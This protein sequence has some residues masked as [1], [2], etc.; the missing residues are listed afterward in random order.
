[1]LKNFTIITT[2]GC[3][4]K[5]DFCFDP[6]NKPTGVDYLL[7][8]EDALKSMPK[9]WNQVSISGGEPTISPHF[10][11]VLKLVHKQKHVKKVVLTTNGTKLLEHIDIIAKSVNHLNV[12]RHAIGYDENVKIFKNKQIID[13]GDLQTA[14]KILSLSGVD[15]TLNCVYTDDNMMTTDFVFDFVR[16]AQFLGASVCFRYDCRTTE[17]KDITPIEQDLIDI[18]YK[19]TFKSECP[20]CRT[21]GFT[22]L[23][24]Q[25]LFKATVN[26]PTGNKAYSDSDEP[27]EVVFHPSG[28]LTRD[29]AEKQKFEFPKKEKKIKKARS[30]SSEST[31]CGRSSSSC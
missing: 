2:G 10:T 29:W 19:P 13:D 21:R 30:S 28:T 6:M 20:V 9:K 7:N 23:G 16:Y 14:I 1:M 8:L 3:N 26:E 11:K 5:C 25:V 27:Y 15:T 24:T 18:K 22:I 31:S 4:A 17:I 12:S